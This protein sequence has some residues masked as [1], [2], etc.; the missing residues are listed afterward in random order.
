MSSSSRRFDA[1][2][3]S[4]LLPSP[5]PFLFLKY[6]V[7]LDM[8]SPFKNNQEYLTRGCTCFLKSLWWDYFIIIIITVIITG[9]LTKWVECSPMVR[10]TWIQSQVASYQRL[11][12]WYLI[13][14]CLTLSDIKYVSTVKWSNPGKGVEPSPTPRCSNYWKGSLLVAL[15]YG[16]QLYF[17]YYYYY[18]PLRI[19]HTCVSW[20]FSTGGWGTGSLFKSPGVFLVFWPISMML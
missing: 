13:P 12:K 7:Y 2:T 4:S 9:S 6:I 1:A 3:L 5:L 19:L 8:K 20:W 17:F 14:P 16:H 15:D 10:E 11:S 18:T